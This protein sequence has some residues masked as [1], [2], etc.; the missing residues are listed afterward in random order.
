MK[1]CV[2]SSSRTL[3]S[4]TREEC[5]DRR[6]RGFEVIRQRYEPDI[7]AE[8]PTW[9]RTIGY[10]TDDGN[11]VECDRYFRLIAQPHITNYFR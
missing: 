8:G 5:C 1:M 4:V 3:R 7:N 11:T 2:S 9:R 10:N 6:V